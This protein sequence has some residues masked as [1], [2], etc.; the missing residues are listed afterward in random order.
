LAN[1]AVAGDAVNARGMAFFTNSRHVDPSTAAEIV[2]QTAE[3]IRCLKP[4]RIYKKIDSCLRGNLGAEID[5]LLLATGSPASFVAPALPQQGRTTVDDCHLINGVPVADTEIGRDPCCPVRESR[6]SVLIASQS[7]FPVGRIGLAG[8]EKGVDGMLKQVRKLLDRGCRHITFDARQTAHLDAIAGLV[9]K[10]F[11]DVLLVGSAGLAG[12]LARLMTPRSSSADRPQR[13]RIRQWLFVCGSA[14]Q[15]L[16]EQAATLVRSTGWPHLA[17][18]PSDLSA[19]DRPR[20]WKP[21]L[22]GQ[23]GAPGAAGLVL[24]IEPDP[25][26]ET[27]QDHHRVVRGLAEAA[28]HLLPKLAPE[29]VFLSGGDTAEAFWRT[30]EA[31]SLIIREELLPGLVLGEFNGGPHHGLPVV[32]KAGAF[33]QADA[34]T[35]LIRC[36]E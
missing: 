20:S 28:V 34:L 10:A 35:Q 23:A 12:S 27:T 24:S 31:R 11:T 5:A 29:G 30:I 4:K 36:L 3:G 25:G 13:P 14:S 8:V 6:L 18:G 21:L 9:D 15:V 1:A 33:G 17:L 19:V 2:R 22:A 32:T 16:A 7:R 26:I